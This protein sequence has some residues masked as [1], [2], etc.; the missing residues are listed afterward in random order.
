M[1]YETSFCGDDFFYAHLQ[2]HLENLLEEGAHHFQLDQI[3]F[4]LFHQD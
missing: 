2:L 3:T 1:S 4:C